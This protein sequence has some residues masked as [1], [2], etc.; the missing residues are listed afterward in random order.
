M[1]MVPVESRWILQ[2]H[3]RPHLH[4]HE[5]NG[6]LRTTAFG[7]VSVNILESPTTFAGTDSEN[8]SSGFSESS[9]SDAEPANHVMA[10]LTRIGKAV[11]NPRSLSLRF[12]ERNQ[13]TSA[14]SLQTGHQHIA[15]N[16]PDNWAKFI[17]KLQWYDFGKT[18]ILQ[19]TN[20]SN[21]DDSSRSVISGDSTGPEVSRTPYRSRGRSPSRFQTEAESA[22]HRE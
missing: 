22:R 21:D 16:R 2:N 7:P 18:H 9:I 1:E 8:V 4:L 10:L 17:H 19:L 20:V 13:A 3:L 14:G 6:A 12:I 11:R 15:G 5:R